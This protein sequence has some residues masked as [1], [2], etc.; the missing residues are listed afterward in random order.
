MIESMAVDIAGEPMQLLSDRAL[1]W[2]AQN[3]LLIADLHL[4]KGNTFREWGIGIPTGGTAHDL[5][6]LTALL[7]HTQAQSLWILGD[8][9]HANHHD[10]VDAQ[11]ARFRSQHASV[12]FAV[13]PGNHDRHLDSGKLGIKQLH[14][15]TRDGPFIFRHAPQPAQTDNA[16]E[17]AGHIHPVVRLPGVGLTPVFWLRAQRTVLPAFSAFTGG[18][19]MPLRETGFCVACNGSSLVSLKRRF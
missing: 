3:R 5:N 6:R 16:H 13:V 1:F 2:P 4:G 11:W 15:G 7:A 14:D 9:L 12:D 17:L 18:Y 10:A 19:V 8:M